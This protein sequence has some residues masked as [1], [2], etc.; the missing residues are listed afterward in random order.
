MFDARER[1]FMHHCGR[2][3]V[4]KREKRR[5]QKGERSREVEFASLFTQEKEQA[6]DERSEAADYLQFAAV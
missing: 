2:A 6:S 5:E 1:Q 3:Q 4:E